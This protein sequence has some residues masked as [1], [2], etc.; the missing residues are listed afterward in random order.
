MNRISSHFENNQP[1]AKNQQNP[2]Y[3]PTARLNADAETMLRDMA[4][5][6]KLTQQVKQ[7]ILES[8]NEILAV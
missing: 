4:Y 7:E 8:N 3:R 5:V 1:K 2:L 6:L